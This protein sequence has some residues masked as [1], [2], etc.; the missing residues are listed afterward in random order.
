MS[1]S[2]KRTPRCGDRKDKF[3]KNYANRRIRRL[4]IDEPPLNN[5]AYRKAF[6]SW[7]ICDYDEVGTSFEEYWERLVKYWNMWRG[8]FGEP[9]PDRDEA[10]KEYC[11]W[12]LRK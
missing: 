3:L 12:Y 4:P 5:K 6:C 1:R 11:R 2:Y 7:E 8:K 10:Y 9:F